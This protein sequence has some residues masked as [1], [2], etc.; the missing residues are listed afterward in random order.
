MPLTEKSKKILEEKITDVFIW[1]FKKGDNIVYNFDILW[2]LYEAKKHYGG[3]K[4]LY[5]KPITI[6]LIS[7][8]E[9]ILNDFVRR[10]QK[11]SPGSLPNIT[12]QMINDFRYKKKG[13]SIRIKKLEKFCHYIDIV[14]KHNIFGS[15]V[16]F[17]KALHF[18]RDVRNKI[19]IQA[20][21]IDEYMVFTDRNLRLSERALERII[22]FMIEKYPRWGKKETA[23]DIPYPWRFL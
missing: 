2:A 16:N 23:D 7:I 3:N 13:Q 19:H 12:P 8:I 17:Y 15:V 11:M 21:D 4:I 22:K 1:T 5:N 6:I 10:I 18:L 9:C 20:S 14:E